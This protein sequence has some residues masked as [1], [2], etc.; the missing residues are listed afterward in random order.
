MQWCSVMSRHRLDLDC[1]AKQESFGCNTKLHAK[2]TL[3]SRAYLVPLY[4]GSW[5]SVMIW[6]RFSRLNRSPS[7][8][9]IL[10]SFHLFPGRIPHCCPRVMAYAQTVLCSH[11]TAAVSWRQDLVSSKIILHFATAFQHLQQSFSSSMVNELRVHYCHLVA[12]NSNDYDS[13]IRPWSHTVIYI[14]P[15]E[16]H[17]RLN[18]GCQTRQEFEKIKMNTFIEVL[19]WAKLLRLRCS[20]QFKKN[21]LHWTGY[22]EQTFTGQ[23]SQ[24]N[25]IQQKPRKQE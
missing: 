5:E 25:K 10:Q 22:I 15:I 19:Q 14:R 13:A 21:S 1:E 4:R 17:K 24:N 9:F 23:N 18:Q 11:I 12:R 7:G 20:D 16:P 8:S 2:H 6:G 3:T